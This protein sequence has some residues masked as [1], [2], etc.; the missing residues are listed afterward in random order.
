MSAATRPV[1]RA[2]P[3][4]ALLA[5]VSV[6]CAADATQPFIFGIGPITPD[7]ER[8]TFTA[9]VIEDAHVDTVTEKQTGKRIIFISL[10]ASVVTGED[11][12]S[13]IPR[14]IR[15]PNDLTI[16]SIPKVEEGAVAGGILANYELMKREKVAI[17]VQPKGIRAMVFISTA[18]NPLEDPDLL[19]IKKLADNTSLR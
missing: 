12:L 10:N 14:L 7:P 9:K 8:W 6:I 3:V 19:A 15:G 17:V 4:V 18:D 13:V 2:S 5:T 1:I 11:P 16:T